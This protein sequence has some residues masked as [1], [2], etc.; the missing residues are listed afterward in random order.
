MVDGMG[1]APLLKM[2]MNMSDK[3][4]NESNWVWIVPDVRD[5]DFERLPAEN[6]FWICEAHTKESQLLIQDLEQRFGRVSW[7]FVKL[8]KNNPAGA[9]LEFFQVA[10]MYGV[11]W[12]RLIFE[13]AKIPEIKSLYKEFNLPQL[14]SNPVCMEP[15]LPE[16]YNKTY[17]SMLEQVLHG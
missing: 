11:N 3:M 6:D 14:V 8:N 13:M 12:N 17:V 4:K 2:E 9:L 16:P 5:A 15:R 7:Y 1:H 10:H